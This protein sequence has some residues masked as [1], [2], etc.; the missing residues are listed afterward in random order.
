[1]TAAVPWLGRVRR[2]AAEQRFHHW[3]LVFPEILG[4]AASGGGFDLVLGNPPWVKVQWNDAPVL[5][6][7]EPGLGVAQ[8][9]S[10]ELNRERSKLINSAANRERYVTALRRSLGEVTFLNSA[11][12]YP[13]LAGMQTNYYKC[14]IV[15][16]WGILGDTGIGGLIHEDGVFDDPK[17]GQFRSAYY[18]RLVAHLQ[19][20]NELDLFAGVDHHKIFSLNVF[21]A[22]RREISVISMANLFHP[23]TINASRGHDRPQDPVPGIKTDDGGWEVRGH[24]SRIVNVTGA[25]LALFARLFEAEEV[26]ALESRLPQVHSAEILE[27]LRRFAEAPRRLA[28]LGEQWTAGEMFHE[29]NS[30]RDGI[31]TRE[32]DPTFQPRSTSEW[33]ISG[34]HFYVGNP[35]VKTCRTTYKH[36]ADYDD[37]DLTE[38]PE[39][40]VPRAVYRPGDEAGALEVFRRSIPVWPRPSDPDEDTEDA[41]AAAVEPKPASERYRHVNRQMCHATNERTLISALLP[42][43]ATAINTALL[44]TFIDHRKLVQFNGCCHSVP[45]DFIMKITG[46]GHVWGSDLGFLPFIESPH[47]LLIERRNLRLSCLTRAYADLWTEVADAGIR[48]EVWATDDPRLCHEHEDRWC[49]LDPERWTWRTPLRSDFARRQALVEIDVLVAQALGL[50]LAEL[51]TIYRVQ[52]P[53]MRQYELVDEYDARGRRLPNTARK[54][55]G[56]KELRSARDSWDGSTPLTVTWHIDNGQKQVTKTFHPPF[57]AVDREGDYERAW[58]MFEG[59]LGK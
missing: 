19:F 23:E 42:L 33:V 16:V 8:A 37:V 45:F 2:L 20:K 56:A 12:E 4:P 32:V 35:I 55:A 29:S 52:F 17:G 51:Q 9:K 58:M 1:M 36:R 59:R 43:G 49:D 14:F 57:T 11:R 25:E 30:Q 47:I 39:D 53:V 18:P 5:Y 28:D 24:R 3:E 6:E 31:I 7:L 50:T 44:A 46:K 22:S 26:P 15:R 34:P 21:R 40:F 13:E 27:V 41:S 38:I 54:D 10:A 48:D